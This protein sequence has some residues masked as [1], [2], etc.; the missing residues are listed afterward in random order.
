MTAALP[1]GAQPRAVVTL[2]QAALPPMTTLGVA[3][4]CKVGKVTWSHIGLLKAT[5]GHTCAGRLPSHPS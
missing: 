4:T 5:R 3:L 2:L 1:S